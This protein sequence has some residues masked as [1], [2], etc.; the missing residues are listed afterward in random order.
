MFVT[1]CHV[2]HGVHRLVTKCEPGRLSRQ[3]RH[4]GQRQDA[5]ADPG[6]QERPRARQDRVLANPHLL[7]IAKV[8][9]LPVGADK[10]GAAVLCLA[11]EARKPAFDLRATTR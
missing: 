11:G 8:D 3:G 6:F 9:G 10:Q 2:V 1:V 4:V 7:L 5:A